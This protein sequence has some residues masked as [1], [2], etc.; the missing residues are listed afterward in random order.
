MR[1]DSPHVL[2]VAAAALLFLCMPDGIPFL[3]AACSSPGAS[4]SVYPFGVVR[5]GPCIAAPP[6]FVVYR[7]DHVT[8]TANTPR[9][10]LTAT[11]ELDI[12]QGGCAVYW[13]TF[14]GGDPCATV[15][16][17]TGTLD[18]EITSMTVKCNGAGESMSIVL[19]FPQNCS[20]CI[21]AQ[22]Y[23]ASGTCTG[24]P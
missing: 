14:C 7:A 10:E 16:A 3:Y 22:C 18:D 4:G 19:G 8:L 13:K 23:E 2:I 17:G 9:C 12:N 20:S 15:L 11:A 21:P 6:E 24:P 5:S 1:Q